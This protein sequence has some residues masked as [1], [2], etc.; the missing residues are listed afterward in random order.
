MSPTTDKSFSFFYYTGLLTSLYLLSKLTNHIYIYHL[1]PSSLDR[2]LHRHRR[3]TSGKE[4][5]SRSSSSWALI[6]ADGIGL[7]FAQELCA[8][9]FNVFLHGRNRDK[10]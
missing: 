10:L 9:G 6:T 5:E 8:R 2:C 7:A 1:R 4:S 3:T